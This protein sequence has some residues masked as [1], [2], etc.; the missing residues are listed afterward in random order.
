MPRRNSSSSEHDNVKSAFMPSFT[1]A[2]K[3]TTPHSLERN[4][5]KHKYG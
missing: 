1:V 5:I 3:K 4:A 2:P